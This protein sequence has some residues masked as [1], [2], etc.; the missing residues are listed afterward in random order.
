MALSKVLG[1]ALILAMLALF[2]QVYFTSS[3]QKE[4]TIYKAKCDS[5]QVAVDSL[6]DENFPCQIELNRYRI[7]HRILRNKNP[8]AADLYSHIISDETE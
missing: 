8:K 3:S 2:I 6:Y 7:A 4:L 1:L 5:L